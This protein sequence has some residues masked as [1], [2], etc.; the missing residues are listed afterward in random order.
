MK[1]KP[2]L[3][4]IGDYWDYD[5]MGKFAKL[6]RKYQGMFSTKFF[7][8]KGIVGDLGIMKITLNLDACPI[9]QRPY[10]LN[11]KYK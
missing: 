11:P 8:I 10:Q 4:K 9:N 1:E 6:L 5:A 3:A 2:K 7:N